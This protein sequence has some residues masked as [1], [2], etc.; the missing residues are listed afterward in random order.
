MEHAV[1]LSP[2]IEQRARDLA[3]AREQREPHMLGLL[4]H[5]PDV[6][7]DALSI[8]LEQLA[9]ADADAHRAPSAPESTA[10]ES[11]EGAPLEMRDVSGR[12]RPYLEKIRV[13]PG[14]MLELRLAD[15]RWI[16]G[17]FVWSLQNGTA[18]LFY[19]RLAGGPEAPIAPPP[20][21]LFR[22]AREPGGIGR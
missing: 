19:V 14:S 13:E 1:H 16:P 5:L 3:R 6:L 4:G 8:G 9:A 7:R 11:L 10:P 21:A 22:W 17:R 18:P 15:G 2:E 20:I 12:V